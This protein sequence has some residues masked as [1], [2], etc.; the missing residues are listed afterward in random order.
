MI[1]AG[2][3]EGKAVLVTE[4]L[5][6]QFVETGAADHQPFRGGG[7]IQLAGVESGED[8]LDIEGLEAVSELFFFMG[9]EDSRWGR[10]PQAPEV[11]RF[12]PWLSE[13]SVAKEKRL[14]KKSEAVG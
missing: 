9:R 14:Q 8:F 12:G 7:G 5:M 2:G 4:P 10:R 6:A 11:Y 13:G 3:L 1:A